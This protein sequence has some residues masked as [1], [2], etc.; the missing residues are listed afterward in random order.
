[1]ELEQVVAAEGGE[2]GGILAADEQGL[3]VDAG[4]QGI[5]RGGGLALDGARA[6]GFLGGEAI[7]LDPFV[8]RRLCLPG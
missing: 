6:G 2:D 7:G 3:R 8:G 1:L 4:F 5:L